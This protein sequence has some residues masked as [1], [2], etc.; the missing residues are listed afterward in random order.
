MFKLH[1]KK[2]KKLPFVLFLAIVSCSFSANANIAMPQASYSQLDFIPT[3]LVNKTTNEE[4]GMVDI[5][6][7]DDL[8]YQL[9][10]SARHYP[11]NFV[12]PTAKYN[13]KQ[14][15]KKFNTLLEPLVDNEQASFELLLRAA[16]IN[17]MGRN[18]DLGSEYAVRA[19]NY[20]DRAIKLNPNNGEANFLYG[21]MLAEGGGFKE[22]QKYLDIAINLNYLEAYQST[23][24]TYLLN[25]KR[26]LALETLQKYQALN[27]SDPLIDDQ[28]AIVHSGKYY[29]WDIKPTQQRKPNF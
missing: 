23:A 14:A 17:I 28:I 4:D 21:M 1:H 9:A 24:Q 12:T 25:D 3:I 10:P 2:N 20:I 13:A 6:M 18:L 19:S 8:I 11:P 7:L 15:I 26:G 5:S 29:I 16:K 22:G 27:P